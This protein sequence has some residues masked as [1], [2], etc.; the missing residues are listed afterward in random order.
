MLSLQGV[1]RGREG[2]QTVVR[3][4]RVRHRCQCRASDNKAH[5]WLWS[6]A[7]KC[8]DCAG[9]RRRRSARENCREHRS[10]RHW[11]I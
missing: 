5:V 11:R 2:K 3:Y 1:C 8:G 7:A 9:Q 6:E 10:N 4:G